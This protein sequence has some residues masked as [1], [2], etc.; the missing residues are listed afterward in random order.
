MNK[1]INNSNRGSNFLEKLF[2]FHD[3]DNDDI[4]KEDA[5]IAAEAAAAAAKESDQHIDNSSKKEDKKTNSNNNN[6]GINIGTVNGGIHFHF[7]GNTNRRHSDDD[8]DIIDADF[9]DVTDAS[10]TT[11]QQQKPVQTPRLT[12]TAKQP[13]LTTQTQ[14]NQ[15][16]QQSPQQSKREL[17]KLIRTGQTAG[18]YALD[19]MIL[20]CNKTGDMTEL[21]DLFKDN[22]A[23]CFWIKRDTQYTRWSLLPAL[24]QELINQ[25]IINNM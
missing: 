18:F 7:D 21:I 6:P 5:R 19:Q 15:Q 17:T 20:K 14:K 12:Q 23:L 13:R 11:R 1:K 8:D 10:N 25:Q 3:V 16:T 9:V 24:V 2:P 22:K 4:T